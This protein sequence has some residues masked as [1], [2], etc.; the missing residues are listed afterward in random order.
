MRDEKKTTVIGNDGLWSRYQ[1]TQEGKS[2]DININPQALKM[3]SAF[4]PYMTADDS[5]W[6]DQRGEKN[7]KLSKKN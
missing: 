5:H 1:A 4:T 3:L 2:E 7:L 6:V